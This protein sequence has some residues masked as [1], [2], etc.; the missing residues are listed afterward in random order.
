MP[1]FYDLFISVTNEK[2]KEQCKE[3]F[4]NLPFL[5][6]LDIKQVP[7]RGRD[8]APFFCAFGEQLQHY[9]YI[10]H[11]H[12]KQSLYNEGATQGWR[13]YLCSTL[14]GSSKNI[15]NI[16]H[17]LDEDNQIGLIYPQTYHR[18]PYF[19]HTWLA[20]K[21]LGRIWCDRLGIKDLPNGYF[22]FPVGSMFWVRG[23]ALA[24]LFQANMQLEDFEVEKGQTD[25]TLAHTLERLIGLCATNQGFEHGIIPDSVNPSWSPW[26]FDQY[27]TKSFEQMEKRLASPEISVI[28]FDI[29]DTLLTRPLLDP[30]TVKRI[31]AER[32]GSEFGQKYLELRP[33]AEV[34]ARQEKKADVDLDEIYVQLAKISEFSK[35][36]L[37]K[38]Q[39]W[40]EEI[41]D[42]ILYPRPQAV[43]LFQ[44]AIA[45]G[46]PVV[47][48][49]D[50]FHKKG[51]LQKVLKKHGIIGYDN[52][53]A[54]SDIGCRKDSG[55]LYET[56][57]ETYGLEPG[58]F[59]MIG[60]NE[61]SD[62]QIPMDK[63][64]QNIH[65]LKP[66]EIG[67]GLPRFSGLVNKFENITTVDE[68][69]TLGIVVYNNFSPITYHK[70]DPLPFVKVDPYNIGFSVV[71]PLM[72]SFT[73]WLIT[74]SREDGIE[75]LYFL[76]REGKIIKE[77]YD[78]WAQGVEDA[79]K[80]VYLEIS[81][82]AISMASVENLDDILNIASTS[83]HVNQLANFLKT[84]Y[85]LALEP[86]QWTEINQR[87]NL[88]ADTD[89]IVVDKDINH[90]VPLLTFLQSTIIAKAKFE[91][92]G[93]LRYL[94]DNNLNEKETS[95]VVDIGFG[96]TIQTYL[97]KLLGYKIHGFYLMTEN[98]SRENAERYQVK[99]KGCFAENVSIDNN[100]P[101]IFKRSFIME[102]LLSCNDPQI[103]YYDSSDEKTLTKVYRDLA[104]QEKDAFAIRD[105]LHTGAKDFAKESIQIRN[106]VFPDLK[107]STQVAESL[108]NQFLEH[109]TQ[110]E[111]EFL[112]KIVS[113]DYY[114]GRD[115][116]T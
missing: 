66:V 16:I 25:G 115:L 40:E 45:T 113:D 47:I 86:Q 32:M 18:V 42:A 44:A 78:I 59:M 22:D 103:V 12:S 9:E 51:F 109:M 105:Q 28:G 70:V 35:E 80:A 89:I 4:S 20:N 2:A 83:Y 79:P 99:I 69:I 73:Q 5:L 31:I 15:K 90:L 57:L 88:F 7:N 65:L 55:K 67:R 39:A 100:P 14:L 24:P 11:F 38:F 58:N 34:Q 82:R 21:R 112:S 46:K 60:D 71:G 72:T 91:R 8:M 68:E 17:L 41:D 49:S 62:L 53:F 87:F 95:A 13:E 74:K 3:K 64:I 36:D 10:A 37:E 75:R 19:A 92:S 93:F 6:R 81:R 48:V 84:R 102:K 104:P 110:D 29:F 101:L 114:C 23:D 1:F 98:R 56:V 54:S 107:P 61:R 97:N 30:E 108:I 94:E 76:S 111:L 106:Q 96:G 116:V 33:L 85:G 63:G 77:I 50:T 26:R 43:A 27:F 52:F